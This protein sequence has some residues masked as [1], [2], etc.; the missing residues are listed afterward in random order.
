MYDPEPISRAM[1]AQELTNEKLA[2]KAEL[3]S[4]TVSAVRNGEEN[5]RLVTLKRIAA[6]LG[7]DVEVRFK[8]RA[9]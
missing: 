7:F 3:S 6:A 5:V 1:E 2:V 4:S 8:K 9:A